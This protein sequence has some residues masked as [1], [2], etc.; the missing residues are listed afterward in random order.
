MRVRPR[1]RG[2]RYMGYVREVLATEHQT[3]RGVI[4]AAGDDLR[5]RRAVSVVPNLAFYRYAV[6]F[7]LFKA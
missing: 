6:S 7:K 2:L 3:V 1:G 5:L 4:I